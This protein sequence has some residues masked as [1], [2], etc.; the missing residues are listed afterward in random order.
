M[1]AT[2]SI[3]H[4]AVSKLLIEIFNGPPTADWN[5]SWQRNTVTEEQWRTL[6]QK[7]RQAADHWR[8]AADI[9]SKPGT[10][11]KLPG[12]PIT[13]GPSGRYSQW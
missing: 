10:I 7:L 9:K 4:R 2:D 6:R 12:R 11:P 13:S 8:S 5:A 1:N 3:F